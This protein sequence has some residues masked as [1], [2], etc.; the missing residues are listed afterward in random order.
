M[1]IVIFCKGIRG[2]ECLKHLCK[3]GA[4]ISMI[5][6]Q[7]GES[8]SAEFST[9]AQKCSAEVYTPSDPNSKESR[10][11]LRKKD[12]DV[13]V[14][15]GYG[16][17]LKKGCFSIPKLNCINLHGGKL[18][19]YRGSSPLNWAL[20]NNET[21]IGISIIEV[22][23]GI[24][25]GD[26]LAEDQMDVSPEANISD[27]H[28]WANRQFPKLLHSVLEQIS[29]GTLNPQ[30]QNHDHAAYYPKR[31]HEDGMIFWDQLSAREVHNR[32]RA[33]TKPYPCARTFFG[34]REVLLIKSELTKSPY[35][36]EA[37]RIYRKNNE[38]LL[39]GAMDQ[40]LWIT[41]AEFTEDQSPLYSNVKRYD[42]LSTH[43]EGAINYFRN[44][45]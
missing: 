8:L 10:N 20:I 45:S 38:K 35:Y 25:S 4:D 24:D 28:E 11:R 30:K 32:I 7:Q 14:L 19:Q 31:F 9:I 15:A 41:S 39:V 40:A 36:G 42:L 5:V 23:E 29:N 16:L 26:V 18:P 1:K 37:G 22:D 3:K 6:L 13:F 44:L 33:L 34:N 43:R 12:A 2:R 27:L 17:I 21:N